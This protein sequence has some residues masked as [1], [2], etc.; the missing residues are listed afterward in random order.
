[1]SA[2]DDIIKERI[3]K[4]EKLLA[5]N[6]NPYP[7]LVEKIDDL[8][9]ILNNFEEGKNIKVAGRVMSIRVHGSLVFF[10]IKND[11]NKIQILL[12]KDKLNDLFDLFLN[13]ID[14]GDFVYVIGSCFLT[15]TSEKTIEADN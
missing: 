14:I 4:K 5:Q 12:K 2:L 1:M 8:D 10:H 3:S 7:E 6:I 13:T 11:N 15:K 9:N